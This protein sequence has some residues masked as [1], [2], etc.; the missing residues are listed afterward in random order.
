MDGVYQRISQILTESRE[1]GRLQHGR[2][3]LPLLR[4]AMLHHRSEIGCE[5]TLRVPCGGGWPDAATWT[6]FGF[7]CDPDGTGGYFITALRWNPQWLP[8]SEEYDIL[9]DVYAGK[10]CRPQLVVPID[11]CVKEATGFES[12]S[13][14]GQREAVRAAFFAPAGSTL[15][16]NLP[17]GSGKSLVGYLPSLLGGSQGN[18]TLFVVPTVALAI[19]QAEKL[20]EMYQRTGSSHSGTPLAWHGGVP[21]IDKELIKRN[22]RDGV[23]PILFTSPESVCGSLRWALYDAARR[24]FLKYFVVDEAHLVSQWGIDFRP[25]FQAL[26]GIWRGL[27]KESVHAM[28]TLLM[29][30]TLTEETLETLEVLF[31]PY[32]A[33]FQVVSAVYLRPEPRY[34]HYKA[35]S[36][37]EKKRCVLEAIR[38]GPRPLILYVTEPKEA[39]AWCAHLRE[40]GFS[41]LATFH[42]NTRTERR[43]QVIA[44]WNR[45]ELDIIVATS[46]FGVGM[47]K[48]DVRMILHASVPENLDR[49]YQEVGRG[50]RD[51]KASVSLLIYTKIDIDKAR[52]MAFPRVVTEGLGRERWLALVQDQVSLEDGLFQMDLATVPAYAHQQ[53]DY[54]RAWN[55]RT[56]LLMVRAGGVQLVAQPPPT[57]AADAAPLSDD[58]VKAYFDKVVLRYLNGNHCDPEYWSTTV[59]AAKES[60]LAASQRNFG[61]LQDVLEKGA[62]MGRTLASLYSICQNGRYV[63]V[64]CSC[65]GCPNCRSNGSNGIAF[66]TSRVP[67]LGRVAHPIVECWESLF[68]M[69]PVHPVVVT[70]SRD[71][72]TA[73]PTRLPQLLGALV[74][75]FGVR[76][77]VASCPETLL[78]N[79]DFFRLY[80]R[81]PDRF[82][83]HRH[84]DEELRQGYDTPLNRVTVLYPWD[85]TPIPRALFLAPK[86][87]HLI[88]VPE[89]VRDGDHPHHLY[90]DTANNILTLRYFQ[91]RLT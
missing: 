8:Q 51:K 40:E 12:Y 7:Y 70:Y 6:D 76:E 9:E 58:E 38:K 80:R 41:R 69:V 59:A 81:V 73:L 60:S 45:N 72:E 22:I 3:F 87:F 27:L 56:L 36:F 53:S 2:D 21:A 13:S 11:P 39:E 64:P 35:H 1:R 54:N 74:T 63:S 30:A 46:A 48:G 71:E 10:V 26:S 77:I 79:P 28:K 85:T 78:K 34:W 67:P 82:L 15:V 86:D 17:T 49:Y 62:E 68:P 91:L 23:Q 50:G 57:A 29:T 44:Q 65:G 88:V 19:D 83:V 47:D 90:R 14:E 37:P 16:V 61:F 75:R 4:Q 32:D 31:S 66:G 55:M 33:P 24:G 5:A 43:M 25:D 52:G 84:L 42:G 89:D 20:R 18:F